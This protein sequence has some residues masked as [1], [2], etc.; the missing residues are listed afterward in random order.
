MKISPEDL[1]PLLSILSPTSRTPD[2]QPGHLSG[3]SPGGGPVSRVSRR[4]HD[5][6]TAI[7]A[8]AWGLIPPPTCNWTLTPTGGSGEG[9]WRPRI[10]ESGARRFWS[11]AAFALLAAKHPNRSPRPGLLDRHHFPRLDRLRAPTLHSSLPRAVG[12]P[13]PPRE[14][15][16][17]EHRFRYCRRPGADRTNRT[18]A[19][20]TDPE[21][22]RA[23]ARLRRRYRASAPACRRARGISRRA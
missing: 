17:D 22:S 21:Q 19:G 10:S 3:H 20:C 15:P 16:N 2:Q 4:N 13:N 7:M 1:P 6:I 14:R 12:F 9:S 18:R 5:W 8:L 23:C 11:I